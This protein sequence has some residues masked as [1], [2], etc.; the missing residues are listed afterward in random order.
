MI[1][2]TE[3]YPLPGWQP[4]FDRVRQDL[5]QATRREQEL[6]PAA[7]E[8]AQQ[9]RLA[10]SV[11]EANKAAKHILVAA[12]QQVVGMDQI[13]LAMQNIEHVSTQNMAS[14][15]QVERAAQALNELSHQLKALAT[16]E[17]A[18]RL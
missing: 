5:A 4:A 3:P 17:E 12:Q 9:A 11:D 1:D 14:T 7:R 18:Q 13:A 16:V 6:A 2:R 15:R 10:Q 8:P